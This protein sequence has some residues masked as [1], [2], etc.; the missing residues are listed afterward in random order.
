LAPFLGQSVH[1]QGW[2]LG[3]STEQRLSA[4]L[5][6][7]ARIEFPRNVQL[8]SVVVSG[9]AFNGPDN[10]IRVL[11]SQMQEIGVQPTFGGNSYNVNQLDLNALG[12][13]FI[14]MSSTPVRIFAI[15][16]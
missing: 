7:R 10:V 9:A 13:V 12:S 2:N 11:D 5:V 15:G 3:G 1:F 6:Y 14:W 16:T 8:R 4:Y